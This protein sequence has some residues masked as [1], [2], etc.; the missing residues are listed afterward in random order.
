MKARPAIGILSDVLT[1]NGEKLYGVSS[2]AVEQIVKLGGVP[3]LL[4]CM[5]ETASVVALLDQVDGLLMAGGQTNIHPTI[6]GQEAGP[7]DGP[8]DE[9]RDITAIK[10]IPAAI[11]RGIPML[12]TC[13]GFQELNV[14]LGGTLRKEPDDLPEERKHGTPASARTEDARYRLRQ[15]IPVNRGG[16]LGSIVETERPLVNSLHSFLIDGLA[17]VATIEATADDGTVEA[18]S[19]RNARNFL[20]GV[21]FHPEYWG[22]R[23]ETSGAIL[24]AFMSAVRSS[25][26]ERPHRRHER[27]AVS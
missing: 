22:E 9:L 7:D 2:V 21:V 11:E 19:V 15:A 27:E 13:R 23:D 6:Y 4:P 8:F 12:A 24:N 25:A 5:S 20:L 1:R 26:Q 10:I 3:T 14:A 16:L 17:S 18:I